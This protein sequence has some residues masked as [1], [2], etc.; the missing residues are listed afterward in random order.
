MYS[1]SVDERPP[2]LRCLGREPDLDALRRAG[3]GETRGEATFVGAR[4]DFGGVG[5]FPVGE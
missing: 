3:T 5:A 1:A 2:R 4:G